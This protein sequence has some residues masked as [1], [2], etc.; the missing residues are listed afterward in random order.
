MKQ[1]F[2]FIIG[3]ILSA[4]L[5]LAASGKGITLPPT[6]VQDEATPL[7]Y[8]SNIN[9]T[10]AGVTCADDVANNRTNCTIPGGGFNPP[11]G[12]D[13]GGVTG[14]LPVANGG[15][16][17]SATATA[18]GVAYGT[19]TSVAVT[20]AGIAGDCLKSGGA[21]SPTWGSCSSISAYGT[22]QDEAVSLTQRTTINFT[23][24][25]VTCVDNAGSSRTDC[26]IS[27]GGSGI[28][29]AEAAAAA[30]AGF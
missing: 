3:F 29:Y 24:A 7:T 12:L 8:R 17:S 4:S 5:A 16:G 13:D 2:A 23:G 21:G 18:G 26:T 1:A 10:G 19:G 15:T 22:V 20:T 27:G 11:Y 6:I 9:M 14:V 30:L 28:S 25:G